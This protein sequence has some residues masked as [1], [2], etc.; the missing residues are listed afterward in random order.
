MKNRVLHVL[1]AKWLR[2]RVK[3]SSGVEDK[4]VEA[5]VCSGGEVVEGVL[6][7]RWHAPALA[8]SKT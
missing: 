8:A 1:Q 5:S 7:R 4:V 3:R 6:H 2:S